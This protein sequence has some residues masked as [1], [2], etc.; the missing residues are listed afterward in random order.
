MESFKKP[1]VLKNKGK[2]KT[3]HLYEYQ[4]P[5]PLSDIDPTLTDQTHLKNY[6]QNKLNIYR[7]SL[8]WVL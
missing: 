7:E 8:L 4:P 2:K 5:R 3:H 6:N 1:H